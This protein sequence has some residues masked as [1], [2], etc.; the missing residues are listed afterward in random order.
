MQEIISI[1]DDSL[2]QQCFIKISI[3]NYKGNE[4][5]KN[6]YI[7]KIVIKREEKLNFII[8]YK[9]KDITKNYSYLEAYSLI[10]EY[11]KRDSFRVL[12]LFTTEYDINYELTKNN[13]W[14]ISKLKPTKSKTLSL[15][16]N[17]T[18][19]NRISPLGKKYLYELKITDLDGTIY[20]NSQDKFRQINH[21]IEILSSLLEN[22]PIKDT[23]NVVDMGAGKGYLTFAL[24]DYLNNSLNKHSKIVG[25]EYRK[26]LV[27]L[28]NSIATNSEFKLLNFVQGSIDNYINEPVDV[29]I[30][31]HACD[32]A[33][34]DALK[35]GIENMASLIVVAPCCHKQIRREIENNKKKSEIQEILKHGIYLERQSEMITD[36][37]RA[38]ILEYYGYKIKIVEFISDVHTPKNVMIIAEKTMNSKIKKEKL[39]EI[40]HLKQFFGIKTHRLEEILH[41]YS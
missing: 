11:L 23:L 20:K 33:T 18:K 5:L 37:I 28:C 39:D 25:V 21:F 10:L 41:L 4:D 22:L 12:V 9:T 40:L 26:E 38:L 27:D 19:Q 30:A 16:H 29:L 1:I 36:A 13:T 32:T 7:K 14:K 35:Y 3:G 34:D 17:N 24:Y 31:L 15:E 8:R 6:I 2:K